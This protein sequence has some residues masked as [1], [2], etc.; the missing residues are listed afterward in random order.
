MGTYRKTN[1]IR[2]I[3]TKIEIVAVSIFFHII[4]G[5]M[6]Y[7]YRL[8]EYIDKLL[9]KTSSKTEQEIRYY[10]AYKETQGNEGRHRY[11]NHCYA[12]E[13]HIACIEEKKKRYSG[14]CYKAKCRYLLKKGGIY[15]QTNR[16]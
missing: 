2:I 13:K 10:E 9:N 1:Q 5:K 11:C 6:E 15:G 8:N 12:C 4:G 7:D 16:P 14:L 3:E